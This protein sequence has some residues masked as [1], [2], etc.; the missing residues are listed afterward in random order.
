MSAQPNPQV[1]EDLK[2]KLIKAYKSEED[3][4]KQCSRQIWLHLGDKNTGFFH[5]STK[6]R[7]AVNK[8]AVI[9][10][11][12]GVSVYKEE[13][14]AATIEDYYSKMF[15]STMTNPQQM[16]DIIE[17]AVTPRV[18]EEQNET[19]TQIPS[20]KEIKKALFSIHLDKAP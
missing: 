18:S 3:F 16:A 17:E 4:W 20:P 8:F 12:Q 2:K 7:K 15:T 19:L 13:E 6:K 9:E 14:I 11:E 10:T 5:A 1:L